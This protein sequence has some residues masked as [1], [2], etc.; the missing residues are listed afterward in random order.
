MNPVYEASD[1]TFLL[2][3]AVLADLEESDWDTSL[4]FLD[5]GAGSGYIGFEATKLGITTITLADINPTSVHQ[6]QVFVE[7]E[8]L[9]CTVVQSDLFSAVKGMYD[10]IVF[11]TPYLPDESEVKD[12]A[13]HGGPEGITVAKKFL[14]QAKDY[15]S[16]KGKIFLLGSSLG[17]QEA[18]LL[19]AQSLGYQQR[20]VAKESHFFESL[21]VYEFVRND[22]AFNMQDAK[23]VDAL[24]LKLP[25][26]VKEPFLLHRGKRGVVFQGIYHG[27]PVVV[28]VLRPGVEAKNTI[29]L[30]ATYLAKANEYGIGPELLQATDDYVIMSYVPGMHIS[31]FLEQIKDAARLRKVITDV[32]EQL[33]TLDKQ[34]LNKFELTNPH[35]HIIITPEDV[36]VMVDFERMRHAARPKNVTQFAQY[37]TGKHVLGHLQE[38]GILVSVDAFMDAIKNYAKGEAVI[39]EQFL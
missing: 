4:R 34:G 1:D 20:V 32:F 29:H 27:K 24:K 2:W 9:S 10:I 3:N 18:F 30:E 22:A 7:S 37:V 16:D 6:M 28:K 36:P 19:Y 15:L 31:A 8:G 26:T 14:K 39:F 13:L 33:R 38:Q 23:Q 25:E 11:N 5:M 35:K 21:L 12:I 17:N